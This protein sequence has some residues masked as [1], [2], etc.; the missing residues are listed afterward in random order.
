MKKILIV[1]AGIS[2]CTL[3]NLLNENEYDIH[4]IDKREYI[5]GNCNDGFYENTNIRHH[6]HGAHIF[7]TKDKEI[8]DY[9]SKFIK[10]NE[11]THR[12]LA[13]CD[14]KYVPVPINEKTLKSLSCDFKTAKEKLYKPYTIKQWGFYNEDALKRIKLSNNEGDYFP[15]QYQGL[16][17]NFEEMFY[18]MI[19]KPNITLE[20]NKQFD[21]DMEKDYDLIFYSGSLD[22]YFNYDIGILPYRSLKFKNE[23]ISSESYLLEDYPVVNFPELVY[24]YTRIIEH[25]RLTRQKMENTLISSEIPCDFIV[26]QNERYYPINNEQNNKLYK[27]YKKRL[28]N[29]IISIGRLGMYK[30]LDMDTSIKEIFNLIKEMKL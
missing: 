5:G 15:N 2:G 4:I 24:S 25:K 14:N 16:I 22:E 21:K 28:S 7:H 9:V 26:G 18:N 3:A 23:I 29:K 30:Y 17:F 27:K 19:N 8:Y 20:L 6:R 11:Y 10:I 12:V 1:G 13:Y